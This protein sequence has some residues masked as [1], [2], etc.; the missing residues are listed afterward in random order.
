MFGMKR[1]ID[2]AINPQN[3][4]WVDVLFI[5]ETR[6]AMLIAFGNRQIWLPKAWIL[7]I[8]RC[9]GTRAVKIKILEYHWA[10]K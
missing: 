7:R 1:L 3:Y 6:K 2:F 9:K 8:K 10:K 4:V 5:K